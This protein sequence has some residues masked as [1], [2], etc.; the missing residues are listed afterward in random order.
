MNKLE[1]IASTYMWLSI[2]WILV[3]AMG[4]FL[5]IL[6]GEVAPLTY[7]AWGLHALFI[8]LA[9]YYKRLARLER[10]D[11]EY[12]EKYREAKTQRSVG[13]DGYL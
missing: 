7:V 13:E 5:H 1:E 10:L 9:V 2:G 11:E 3:S 12:K 4:V 8:G 6:G